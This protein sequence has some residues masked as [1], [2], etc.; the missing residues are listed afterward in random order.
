MAYVSISKDVRAYLIA[1][2][3]SFVDVGSVGTILYSVLDNNS[4]DDAGILTVLDSAGYNPNLPIQT[5]P[6]QFLIRNKESA[7]TAQE[8]CIKVQSL[9]V[10][11]DGETKTNFTLPSGRRVLRAFDITS[12]SFVGQDENTRYMYS[13]EFILEVIGL[14]LPD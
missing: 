7:E 8:N 3:T 10:N 13:M 11:S 1:N 14:D 6:F 4:V 9:F 12:P 5:I 2:I